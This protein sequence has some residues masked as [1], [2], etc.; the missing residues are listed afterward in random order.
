MIYAIDLPEVTWGKSAAG[1]EQLSKDG[2]LGT[3]MFWKLAGG[4]HRGCK[5]ATG[6]V[7]E[8]QEDV[9]NQEPRE[10]LKGVWRRKECHFTEK[11]VPGHLNKMRTEMEV[12]CDLGKSYA[13]DQLS[14]EAL[15]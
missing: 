4:I 11:N 12:V 15:C 7:Q 1:T 6:V 8:I 5:G 9:V 10:K 2:A 13:G 14:E 3:S